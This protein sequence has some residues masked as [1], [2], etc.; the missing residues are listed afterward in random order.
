MVAHMALFGMVWLLRVRAE[1]RRCSKCHSAATSSSSLP[2]SSQAIF[3]V[4]CPPAGASG[5]PP[6]PPPTAYCEVHGFRPRKDHEGKPTKPLLLQGIER[7]QF[8]TVRASF[9]WV[10]RIDHTM[11]HKCLH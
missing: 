2:A 5:P 10:A 11:K 9:R 1:L 4:D 3:T 8:H 7:L 6:P